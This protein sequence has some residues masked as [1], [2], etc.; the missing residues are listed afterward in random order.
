MTISIDGFASHTGS[1]AHNLILSDKREQEVENY[2]KARSRVFDPGQP[3]KI[4][5]NFKGFSGSPPGENALFRSV[6]I[7]VHK[8]GIVPPPSPLPPSPPPVVGL[9]EVTVWINAFINKD[10]TDGKGGFLTFKL[11]RG[12]G[13]GK[14]VIPGPIPGFKDCYMT[15]NRDFYSSI[16]EE[17]RIHA[18]IT[19]DFTAPAPVVSSTRPK[20]LKCS[21]SQRF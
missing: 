20:V 9:S 5:R 16:T 21:E 1:A 10:V 13:V 15:D 18:E 2:L 8:P 19:I 7:V 12:L 6:R 3:H 17:A 4:N 11:T 14:S